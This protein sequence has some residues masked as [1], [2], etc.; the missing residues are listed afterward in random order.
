[1]QAPVGTESTR[2]SFDGGSEPQIASAHAFHPSFYNTSNPARNFFTPQPSSQT[3]ISPN[4]LCQRSKI[5]PTY[6]ID[7]LIDAQSTAGGS[8]LSA[9]VGT[10]SLART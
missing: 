1:M 6:H 8:N 5:G 3:A 7:V 4:K 10:G 9:R 2:P